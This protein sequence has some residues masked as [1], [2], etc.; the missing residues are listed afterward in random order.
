MVSY[1]TIPIDPRVC[2][3]SIER[4]NDRIEGIPYAINAHLREERMQQEK[5]KKK[6]TRIPTAVRASTGASVSNAALT[7]N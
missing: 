3:A 4:Y 1:L 7:S 6:C 5:K 2:D